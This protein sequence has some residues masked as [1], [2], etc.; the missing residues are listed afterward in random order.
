MIVVCGEALVDMV[1]A[2]CGDEPGYVPRPGGSP[3]NVAIGL[4]RLGAPTGFLSRLSTDAFGRLLRDHLERNGVD[5]RYVTNG[6]EPT[7]LAFV[8][9]GRGQDVEYG[10]YVENSADRNLQPSDL[11]AALAPRVEALHFGSISLVLE[12]GATTLE[13]RMRRERGRRL[14]SLDPNVRP[15]LIPDRDEYCRRLEGWVEASDLVKASA[16]DLEW[17][18]PDTPPDSIAQRWLETGPAAV[19]VTRGGEGSSAYGRRSSASARAPVV[20]VVDTVGAGDAFMSGTLA[21][22]HHKQRLDPTRLAELSS[23]ELAELLRYAGG[24]SALTCTRAGADPPTAS[25]LAAFLS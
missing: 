17:L 24:T 5:T 4:S 16:A 3:C 15:R 9:A 11:P 23:E 6:G 10:F 12:P 14:I 21:W 22:L 18:Y 25:E 19:L 20:E 7:T 8:H 2:H 13:D 1:P